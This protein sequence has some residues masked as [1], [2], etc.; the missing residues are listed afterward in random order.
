[1]EDNFDRLECTSRE[2]MGLLKLVVK[3]QEYSL[4]EDRPDVPAS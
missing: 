1:M 3:T 2:A 4:V